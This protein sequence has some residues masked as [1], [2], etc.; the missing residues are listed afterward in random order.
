MQATQPYL[1]P[2]EDGGAKPGNHF[3]AHERTKNIRSSQHRL[4]LLHSR[5][6]GTMLP[7]VH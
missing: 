3:Q 6:E 4:F 7:R 2:W 5:S 1:D